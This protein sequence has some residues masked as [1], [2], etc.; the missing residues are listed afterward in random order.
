MIAGEEPATWQTETFQDRLA[1]AR[2]VVVARF[3]SMSRVSLIPSGV[4]APA[5]RAAQARGEIMRVYATFT[6]SPDDY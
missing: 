6:K 5:R 2:L 3:P 1:L 4:Q